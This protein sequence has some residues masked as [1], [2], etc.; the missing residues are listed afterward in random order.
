MFLHLCVILFTGGLTSQHASQ[1]TRLLSGGV[2]IRGGSE[3]ASGGGG[4]ASGE[5]VWAD[6]PSLGYYGIRST[7][8]GYSS[9]W[10]AFSFKDDFYYM[11]RVIRNSDANNK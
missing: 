4:S 11:S 6:I 10:N 8:R 5:G 2:C 3:S 9:Y 1:V 7:S